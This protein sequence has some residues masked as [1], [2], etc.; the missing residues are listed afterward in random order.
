MSEVREVAFFSSAGTHSKEGKT[1]NT[2]DAQN[3]PKELKYARLRYSIIFFN[4]S[5]NVAGNHRPVMVVSQCV[6]QAERSSRWHGSGLQS[7]S[8]LLTNWTKWY[9]IS[10]PSSTILNGFRPYACVIALHKLASM[11][12]HWWGTE[13]S[14]AAAKVRIT[15]CSLNLRGPWRRPL[16]PWLWPAYRNKT[17]VWRIW[18]RSNQRY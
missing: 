14:R 1:T 11:E 2:V 3:P 16:W 4:W 7:P 9:S 8:A 10:L 6:A 15:F 13:E 5:M 12:T 17:L 18:A